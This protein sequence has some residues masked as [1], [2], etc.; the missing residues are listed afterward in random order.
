M[1]LKRSMGRTGSCFDHATA[2]SYWSIF[3]HEYYYRHAFANLAEITAGVK[4][5]VHRYNTTRKYSKNRNISPLN[6]ELG[7]H[8]TTATTT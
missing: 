6:Y 8:H 4:G 7:S 2:A 5:Y 1:G 3:K